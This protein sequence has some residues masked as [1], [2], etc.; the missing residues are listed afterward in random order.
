MGCDKFQNSVTR[1]A[2]IDDAAQQLKRSAAIAQSRTQKLY[3]EKNIIRE[4][5]VGMTW[6]YQVQQMKKTVVKEFMQHCCILRMKR[7]NE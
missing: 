1:S 2:T 4:L 3:A 5:V 6:P 7:S